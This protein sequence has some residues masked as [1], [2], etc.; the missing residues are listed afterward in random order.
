MTRKG[1]LTHILLCLC[2]RDT[3]CCQNLV[4]RAVLGLDLLDPCFLLRDL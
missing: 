1:R 3:A 2:Q 4:E